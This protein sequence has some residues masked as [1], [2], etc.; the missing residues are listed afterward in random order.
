MIWENDIETYII[1][2]MKGITIPGLMHDTGC[3]ELVH[4][5]DPEGWYGEGG[6][7]RVQD[8]EHV[9]THGGFMSMYGKPNTIL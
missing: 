8:G 4:W 6:G 9:Y 5:D 2:Y 1:S 3:L 7:W